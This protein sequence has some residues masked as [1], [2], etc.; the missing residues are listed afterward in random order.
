MR[1][2]CA[3]V[4]GPAGR[5]K[6]MKA[7]KHTDISALC[8]KTL[9][10]IFGG[11]SF[12]V[13]V[14]PLL[15]FLVFFLLAVPNPDSDD[16]GLFFE[17][18][19]AAH[20][21]TRDLQCTFVMDV[22][23]QGTVIP[24]TTA[25]L[26]YRREPETVYLQFLDRHKGRKVAYGVKTTQG[27]LKVRPDGLMSLI[28]VSLDPLGDQAMEEAIDPITRQGVR[29]ILEQAERAYKDAQTDPASEVICREEMIDGTPVTTMSLTRGTG[30]LLALS[31][32]RDSGLPM[33]IKRKAGKNCAT[34][35]YQNIRTNLGLKNGD[36]EP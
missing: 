16:A 34:Y 6:G 7:M 23:K 11:I 2:L 21:R 9:L 20:E 22:T 28:T 33:L 17:R 35:R 14:Q 3:D 36:F 25:L 13:S 29:A 19:R 1:R 12:G 26:R 4:P 24:T 15:S 27:K 31:I 32:R 8:G 30:D 18:L 5:C 10:R